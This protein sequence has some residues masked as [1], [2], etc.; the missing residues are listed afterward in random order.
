MWKPGDRVSHRFHAELGTGR[1][2]GV[3]GRSVRVQFPESGQTLSFAAGTARLI[4]P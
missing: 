3:Q 1:V 4:Q 2:L